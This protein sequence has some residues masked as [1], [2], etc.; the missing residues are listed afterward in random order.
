MAEEFL[1]R[2]PQSRFW[3]IAHG[4]RL[5][6]LGRGSVRACGGYDSGDLILGRWPLRIFCKRASARWCGT[7][8]A[9]R[10]LNVND[11]QLLEW[12]GR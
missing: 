2:R 7:S 11:T 6:Q 12:R 3:G 1:S 5:S 8:V 10:W 9:V 4:V